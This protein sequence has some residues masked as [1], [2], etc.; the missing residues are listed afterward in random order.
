[1]TTL[2]ARQRAFVTEYAVDRNATQAAIRAG[3]SPKTAKSIGSEN[4]TKPDIALA[5]QN[6]QSA[7]AE[8][9]E[10]DA[11]WVQARLVEN[12]ERAMQVEPVRDA[13][14]DKTG[15]YTY[16]GAVANTALALLAKRTGGFAERGPL[17]FGQEGARVRSVEIRVVYDNEARD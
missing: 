6:T 4:L 13:G 9:T 15:E 14:G 17:D 11:D 12:I 7:Q 1:M 3:Y 5:I 16:Q 8:R 2:T 10:I